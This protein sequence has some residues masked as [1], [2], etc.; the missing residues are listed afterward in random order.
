MS[1]TVDPAPGKTPSQARRRKPGLVGWVV[2]RVGLDDTMEDQYNRV[3]PK[4][5]TNYIYCFGGVA[6][7][8]FL[9]LIHI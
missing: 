1:A 3:V 9:S 7:V 8:L 5:A 4:H 6:F 2:N